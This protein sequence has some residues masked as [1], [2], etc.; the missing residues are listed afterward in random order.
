MLKKKSRGSKSVHGF[1]LIELLVV[2]AIIAI[3]AAML[4]PALSKARE[5]ARQ[6]VCM[7]NLKQMG[8]AMFMYTQD[9]DEYCP[10]YYDANGKTWRGVMIKAGVIKGTG[11]TGTGARFLK[12]SDCPSNRIAYLGDTYAGVFADAVDRRTMFGNKNDSLYTKLAQCKNP[13]G[14]AYLIETARAD[15][16]GYATGLNALYHSSNRHSL[17]GERFYDDI[18]N[19]GS[20]FTFVDGHVEWKNNSFFNSAGDA[21]AL[22]NILD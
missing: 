8:I 1:T 10:R 17:G 18:H 4:L 22:F 2:V 6:A 9:Y 19:G 3:L 21:W 20:N 7:N 12:G 13:S 11:S 16:Y 5:K 14:T 15:G